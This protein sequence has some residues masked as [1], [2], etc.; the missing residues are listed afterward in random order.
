MAWRLKR[1]CAIALALGF[2]WPGM[3]LAADVAAAGTIADPPA[4]L[5]LAGHA[6]QGGWLRGKLGPGW[7]GLVLAGQAVPVA[8]DGSFFLA[9]DR[10]APAVQSVTLTK[11]DGGT[12]AWSLAVAPRAWRIER[13]DVAKRPGGLPDADYQRMRAGELAQIRAARAIDSAIAGWRQAFAR[14]APGRISGLFGAQRIY[15]GEPGSY[16]SGMD[17]AGGAG[18]PFTAPAD[19][20][21]VLA[22][23]APFSLEGHLV[24]IDH[25]MG[26]NSAFLHASSLAVKVGD[27]VRQG[28]V[29]GRIGKSGRATGPHLHWSITWRGRRLDPALFLP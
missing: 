23:T 3:V 16:H 21:V 15:R 27:V 9:F 28:Q 17:I 26:L 7:T 22:A 20:V 29:I 11:A 25:G 5:T 18:V 8:P 1:V 2:V 6:T 19:G 14:P 13:I 24:I 12:F 10:D 4:G